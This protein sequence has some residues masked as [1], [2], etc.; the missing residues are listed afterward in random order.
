MSRII[1]H[2]GSGYTL[3]TT[4]TSPDGGEMYKQYENKIKSADFKVATTG[5]G[6]LYG[7]QMSNCKIL[8]VTDSIVGNIT[9][10]RLSITVKVQFAVGFITSLDF[11]EIWIRR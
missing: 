10:V 2:R 6:L 1:K 7:K 8:E 5:V 3:C 11:E 4:G 9:G